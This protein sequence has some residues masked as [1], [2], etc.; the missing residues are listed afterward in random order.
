MLDLAVG[1]DDRTLAVGGHVVWG[2]AEGCDGT[3]GKQPGNLSA[4]VVERCEILDEPAR[5]R[6]SDNRRR[7]NLARRRINRTASVAQRLFDLHHDLA[8]LSSHRGGSYG[9]SARRTGVRR[10]PTATPPKIRMNSAIT[11][12]KMGLSMKKRGMTGLPS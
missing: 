6:V 5:V 2:H 11:Q 1:T 10:E 3:L 12:A 9:L 8:N 7:H 4:K